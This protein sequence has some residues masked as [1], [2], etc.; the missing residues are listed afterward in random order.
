M[1]QQSNFVINDQDKLFTFIY[2][3]QFWSILNGFYYQKI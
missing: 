2:E 1:D 3:N